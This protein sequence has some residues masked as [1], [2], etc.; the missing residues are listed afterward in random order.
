MVD[1]EVQGKYLVRLLAL[2]TAFGCSQIAQ[3]PG[4]G[5]GP[6]FPQDYR[7]LRLSVSRSIDHA[8]DTVT[9]PSQPAGAYMKRQPNM[10]LRELMPYAPFVGAGSTTYVF[11]PNSHVAARGVRIMF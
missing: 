2:V 3:S 5:D 6:A 8:E 1:S 10:G 4:R 7:P 11:R 9:Q